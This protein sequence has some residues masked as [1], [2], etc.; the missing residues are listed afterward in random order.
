VELRLG[1][2][3]NKALAMKLRMQKMPGDFIE[4]RNQLPHVDAV[5]RRFTI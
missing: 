2:L 1:S 5:N 4:K 3:V